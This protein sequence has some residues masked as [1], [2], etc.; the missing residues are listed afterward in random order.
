MKVEKFLKL[1]KAEQRVEVAKDVLKQIK[2]KR[3][4]GNT[5]SYIRGVVVDNVDMNDSVREN[6]DKIEECDVCAMG[7]CLLSITKYKNMLTF[8][9]LPFCTSQMGSKVVDLLSIFTPKQLLLIESAFEGYD[10]GADRVAEDVFGYRDGLSLQ[11][12][13]KVDNF[14]AKYSEDTNR[15]KAI[16]ENIISHKGTFKL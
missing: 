3:Y 6:F 7:A 10:H 1:T 8:A 12:I 5:G 9:E 13:E 16:M 2:A 11:E 4:V 15:L 14:Y